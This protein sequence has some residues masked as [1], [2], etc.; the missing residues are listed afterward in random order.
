MKTIQAVARYLPEK[1]GGIQ[2]R[3]S[4]LLPVLQ[5]Y[6][7]E[8]KIAAAQDSKYENTYTH[9]GIEVYRYPV[10][11]RPKAEPNH[12]ESPH[13][14]F[15][16][17][18]HWL[19]EQKADIYHQ[20][21][22]TPKCG[23]PHLRLAKELGMA[24]VVSIRLPNPVCQRETLMLNGQEVCDGKIDRVR[25]S[26]CCGVSREISDTVIKRLA[27]TPLS[28]SNLASGLLYQLKK[29]PAPLNTTATALLTPVSVPAYVVAR[30]RG[31][32]EMAEFA[33]RIVTLSERLYETLLLNGVPQEKLIIC[34]TGVP[35]V[36]LTS[37]QN[38]KKIPNKNL[39]VIFLGRWNRNKGLHILVEAVKSLPPD[40]PIELTIYGSAVDDERY[41][42][43]I[44][45]SI[46]NE[47]RIR[48]AETLTREELPSVLATYDILA[49]PAQWFDVRPM[50]ILE[51]HTAK[52]PV[53]GSDVGGVNELIKHNV[54]GL[55]LPPTDVQAWAEAFARLSEDPNLL[56]K[57]RQ[58]IQPVRTMSME[59][60]DT[61]T[62]YKS[63]LKEKAAQ[64][65][66]NFSNPLNFKQVISS[67]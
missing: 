58:G 2:I 47:P 31:L 50:S 17:F 49:L 66:S 16:Y 67:R 1:C 61:V 42:Q 60:A 64:T 52:L 34:K 23:L 7:V 13:G 6:G 3:L 62:L 20:H 45:Q 24:T 11:P 36:F 14:R 9:N 38:V 35:D 33:D 41:R 19:K 57:L 56:D 25:C 4:E 26:H 21:Q 37:A 15:E 51:A 43:K 55:L 59:A 29:A 46:K 30:R 65:E 54:D 48:I 10:F 8:S 63:I 32:L 39:R 44:I 22:W 28:I 12:G 40:L 5:A 27:H 18:A 53:L